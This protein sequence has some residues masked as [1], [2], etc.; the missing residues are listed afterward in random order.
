MTPLAAAAVIAVVFVG[1][2]PPSQTLVDDAV[3]SATDMPAAPAEKQVATSAPVVPPAA[4][5]AVP[6][7]VTTPRTEAAP[8]T[9][10]PLPQ[11]APAAPDTSASRERGS[12]DAERVQAFAAPPP[13]LAAESN[14]AP[15]KPASPGKAA[16]AAS[17]AAPTQQ[18]SRAAQDRV[19]ALEVEAWFARIRA[20]RDL[21]REDEAVRE[22]ARF[23]A[24]Y[25]NADTRL[26]A[27]LREWAKQLPR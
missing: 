1:V 20:M 17:S 22:L 15:A 5:P 9:I 2:K 7:V 13:A 14:A 10:A 11:G 6:P 23:R 27:D 12:L 8:A 4:P 26:P 19:A 25:P 21:G 24:A 3:Q 18:A 16:S